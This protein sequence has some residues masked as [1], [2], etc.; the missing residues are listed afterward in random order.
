MVSSSRGNDSQLYLLPKVPAAESSGTEE[1][2][3][4]SSAV[5]CTVRVSP[6]VARK[7]KTKEVTAVTHFAIELHEVAMAIDA[8]IRNSPIRMDDMAND[9]DGAVDMAVGVMG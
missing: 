6:I 5:P 2:K 9:S 8:D 1:S 4:D 7:T 3:D